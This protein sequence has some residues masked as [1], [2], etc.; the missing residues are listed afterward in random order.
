MAKSKHFSL[1]KK[2]QTVA[3][4]RV[5]GNASLVSAVVKV[6]PET[7]R[8]WKTQ[9]WW[10][11]LEAQLQDEENVKKNVALKKIV[12][13]SLALIEDRLENG[14]FVFDQKS[15]T[16]LR[17]PVALRDVAKVTTELMDRQ[18]MLDKVHGPKANQQTVEESLKKIAAEFANLAKG[19]QNDQKDALRLQS[20]IGEGPEPLEIEF[21][22]GS[23]GEEVEAGGVF[24]ASEGEID[25]EEGTLP[26]PETDSPV[27][28][29]WTTE[30]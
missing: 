13:K 6:A 17:K 19:L 16:I 12:D 1:D 28:E 24:Q 3:A 30:R 7:I 18:M 21:D 15:G 20:H 2:L 9:S 8:W 4:Y 25:G 14:D 10:S 26:T 23:S 27:S 11:E 5:M 22:E 29:P